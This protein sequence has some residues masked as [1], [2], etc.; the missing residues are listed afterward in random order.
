VGVPTLGILGLP[1]WSRGTKCHLDVGI[2]E[3][4]KVYYKGEGDGLPQVRAMVSLVHPNLPVA[5]PNTKSV[6]TMH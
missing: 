6:Q 2:V 1:F 5:Y 4:Y 3:R